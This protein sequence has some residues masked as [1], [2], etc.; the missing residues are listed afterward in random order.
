MTIPLRR[1]Q[2]EAITVSRT[3][4]QGGKFQVQEDAVAVERPLNIKLAPSESKSQ[5]PASLTMTM[6]TP[7]HDHDLVVGHLLTE[8]IIRQ[9]GDIVSMSADSPQRGSRADGLV[10]HLD[11]KIAIESQIFHRYSIASSAC[12]MCGKTSFEQVQE[13][14]RVASDLRLKTDRISKFMAQARKQQTLFQQTGG[15]HGATLFVDEDL[16]ATREDVGRH[17]AMDK[18]VGAVAKRDK[19]LFSRSVIILSGRTSFELVHKAAKVGIPIIISVGAPS[20]LAICM[21]QDLGITMIGFVK[22]SSFN[23]YSGEERI[24]L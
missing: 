21:A 15:S 10:V 11:P 20:S 23:I 14:P 18:L 6:R 22:S 16:I 7:G 24:I 4:Y 12:G 1:P 13:A 9:A 8:G 3:L 17:N 2:I 5:A 19:S